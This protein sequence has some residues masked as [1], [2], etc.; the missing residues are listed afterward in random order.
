MLSIL[1]A[2]AGHCLRFVARLRL[3]DLPDADAGV[4]EPRR[5]A[6]APR[7]QPK[8]GSIVKFWRKPASGVDSSRMAFNHNQKLRSAHAAPLL[9]V[10]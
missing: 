6:D 7:K 4:H 9:F 3:Q 5:L 1:P 2:R 8:S 10:V